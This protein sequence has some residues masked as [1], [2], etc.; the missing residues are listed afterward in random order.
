MT[1]GFFRIK[2]RADRR[3]GFPVESRLRHFRRRFRELRRLG[4]EWISLLLEMEELWLQT[5]KRSEAEIRLLAE[6]QKLRK[7]VNRNLRSAELQLAHVRTRMHFPE[8]RVPSRLALA[9]RNLNFRMAKRLA[10]SR[11]D[12]QFFWHRTCRRSTLLLRPDRVLVHFLK[13]F[14]LFL[15]FMR[16]LAR[17]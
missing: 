10:Y 17:A 4:V 12:L 1:H 11:A 13:D 14:Q 16:D 6:I 5:R 15:L 3:S 9:F 2:D 8:L 7:Q